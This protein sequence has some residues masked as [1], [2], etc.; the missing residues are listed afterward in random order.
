MCIF[1]LK[2][3]ANQGESRWYSDREREFTFA[4]NVPTFLLLCVSQVSTDFDKKMVGV[5]RNRYLTMKTVY[6]VSIHFQVGPRA[7]MWLG[8]DFTLLT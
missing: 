5:S 2:L 6:N 4:K 1:V 8:K 7:Y 3:A